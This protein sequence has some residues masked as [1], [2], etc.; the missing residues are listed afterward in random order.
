MTR[1]NFDL[2]DPTIIAD[3]YPHYAWLRDEG[4]GISLHGSGSVG[5]QPPR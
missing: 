5:A 2:N 3:P 1:T 4:P